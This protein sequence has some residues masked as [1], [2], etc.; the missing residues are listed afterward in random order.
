MPV[1]MMFIIFIPANNQV[2]GFIETFSAFIIISGLWFRSKLTGTS[3][4]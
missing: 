3:H 1:I 2:F 4:V